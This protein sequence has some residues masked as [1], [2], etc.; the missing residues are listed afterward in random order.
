MNMRVPPLSKNPR[1]PQVVWAAG[2]VGSASPPY[3][4]WNSSH[5]VT[6]R[7]WTGPRSVGPAKPAV[8]VLTPSIGTGPVL[9][10]SV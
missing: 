2:L 10:S 8:L 6:S 1:T 9:T 4:R 7:G 5:D 3:H